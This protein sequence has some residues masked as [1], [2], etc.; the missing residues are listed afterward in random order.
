MDINYINQYI[1]ANNKFKTVM[2]NLCDNI[3]DNIK[4][5]YK[6]FKWSIPYINY[7]NSNQYLIYS[8]TFIFILIF[9]KYFLNVLLLYLLSDS[10]ILSIVVLHKNSLNHFS[11]KLAKN[12]ISLSLIYFNFFGSIFTLIVFSFLYF[13]FN[14]YC[15]KILYKILETVIFFIHTNIPGISLIYPNINNIKYNKPFKNTLSISSE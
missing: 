6:K 2:N 13:E 5:K 8:C 1:F 11:R 7:F 14:K 3:V 12:I 9:S 10:I 4:K 15:N